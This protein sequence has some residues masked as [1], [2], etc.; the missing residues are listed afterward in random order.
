[1][2]KTLLGQSLVRSANLLSLGHE[3]GDPNSK[4]WKRDWYTPIKTQLPS[5]VVTPSATPTPFG[6]ESSSQIEQKYT[7]KVKT[8]VLDEN[9]APVVD[10]DEEDILDLDIYSTVKIT[11]GSNDLTDA[12]IR[13]AV[14]TDGDTIPGISKSTD[15]AAAQAK[16][17]KEEPKIEEIEEESKP[18]ITKDGD[19]DEIIN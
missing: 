1:M 12:A 16:E 7:F 10:G 8:W 9:Y 15:D 5:A 18:D 4:H 11:N 13:G 3:N 17:V 19:G 14:A 6:D 2:S